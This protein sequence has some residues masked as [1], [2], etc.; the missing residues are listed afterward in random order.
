MKLYISTDWFE[1]EQRCEDAG[2]LDEF[3]WEIMG[4]NLFANQYNLRLNIKKVQ[5]F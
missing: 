5:K 2:I 1:D 4:E 3:D